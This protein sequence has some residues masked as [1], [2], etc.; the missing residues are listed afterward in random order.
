MPVLIEMK[1]Y[2]HTAI[3]MIINMKMKEADTLF[4]AR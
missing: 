3:V 2:I 4:L 1:K